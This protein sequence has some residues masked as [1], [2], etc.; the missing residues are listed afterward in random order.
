MVRRS[1]VRAPT[2]QVVLPGHLGD[3]VL[4]LPALRLLR[5]ALPDWALQPVG[6]PAVASDLL[7]DQGCGL[8]VRSRLRRDESGVAVLLA[9]S[10]RVAWQAAASR[11]PTRIGLPSDHRRLLLTDPVPGPLEALP[12]R[13]L[14][15]LG[16]GEHQRD[17]YLRVARHATRVLGVAAQGV[18][19]ASFRLSPVRAA[20]V[21][22]LW[23]SAGEPEVLL[24]PWA[25]GLDTKRWTTA[26]WVSLGRR[27]QAGGLRIAVTRG[28]SAPDGRCAESVVAGLG[29]APPLGPYLWGP[30]AWAGV[31]QRARCVVLPDTGL[32]HLAS[33][34]GSWPIVLFGPTDPGRHGPGHGSTLE[35]GSDLTCWPCYQPRCSHGFSPSCTV[36]ISV[37]QVAERVELAVR[38]VA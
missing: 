20:T 37:E 21:L 28:P 4:A 12:G 36:S 13:R 30:S 35:G 32:A 6:G 27:L 10:L 1:E 8:P 22:A 38:G 7:V 29:G 33:A 3:T 15:L 11:L 16:P 14:R 17:S 18:P 26:N 9:P 25:E 19:D 24:H 34:V 31:A 5:N 2:L 23:R